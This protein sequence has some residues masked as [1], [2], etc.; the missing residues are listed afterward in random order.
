MSWAEQC[1]AVIPCLNEATAIGKV[2]AGVRRYVPNVWVVDDGSTDA[3]SSGA[4]AAGARVLR[5]AVPQGKGA[6][7]QDG[8][9]AVQTAGFQWAL[10]LDG[11]G[12]HASED[13]PAFFEL[14]DETGARLVSGNRMNDTRR[15]PLVRRGVN[16]WMSRQLSRAAGTRLPDTQCG[17]RLMN[18]TDWAALPVKAVH[19]EI[20]SEILIAFARAGHRIGFV[21]IQ[22]I[23]EDERSKIHPLRDTVRW[24][25]WWQRTGKIR[26]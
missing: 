6:S 3:T 19:F 23:Y 2:I 9:R 25:R 20:E 14:A 21:P 18:L 16:L 24:F 12:Q 17:F 1:A 8:W 4:E 15:M 11:D 22:V 5:H 13:I 7:L 26:S 10:T